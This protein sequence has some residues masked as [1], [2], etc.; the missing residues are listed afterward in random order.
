[1]RPIRGVAMSS[2]NSL[3][4]LDSLRG[5]AAAYVVVHHAHLAPQSAFGNLLFFGQ[6]AV[7]LFFLL[8]G[9]V[10]HYSTHSPARPRPD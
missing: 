4:Q 1:M 3:H 10:I 7:I 8:S 9:F 5:F 2:A 6:E